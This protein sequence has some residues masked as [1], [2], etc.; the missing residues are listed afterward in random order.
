MFL[1]VLYLCALG[2][3]A[4]EFFSNFM[5][6]VFHLADYYIYFKPISWNM[7]RIYYKSS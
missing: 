2:N 7:K 3:Y 1:Y 5:A 6:K 4:F